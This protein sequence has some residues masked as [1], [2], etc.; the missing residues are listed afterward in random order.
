MQTRLHE[1]L[2]HFL[3][4]GATLFVLSAFMYDPVAL[5]AD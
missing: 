3:V 5:N 2:V 4:I 1:P